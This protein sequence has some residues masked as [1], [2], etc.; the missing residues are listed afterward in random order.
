MALAR[1]GEKS[2]VPLM[3]AALDRVDWK[4]LDT[5]Q[6]L[7]WL[8]AT[9]L[10]FARHGEPGE[11][12]RAKVLAKVLAK[13]DPAYPTDEYEINAELRG[14]CVISRR[15][16]WSGGRWRF[17]RSIRNRRS[18]NGWNSYRA[19]IDTEPVSSG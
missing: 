1:L 4:A 13:V 7:N 17:S 3:L 12:A 19:T 2:D 15:R 16:M 11:S 6:K 9:G 5:P 8:R 10:V 18:R 14:C